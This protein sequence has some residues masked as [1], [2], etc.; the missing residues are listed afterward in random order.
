MNLA[1]QGMNPKIL[2]L[3]ETLRG[4]PQLD[5]PVKHYQIEGV[6]VR[7]LFLPKGT[8]LTGKIHNTEHISILS[9][10]ELMV[11]SEQGTFSLKAPYTVIDK[12]GTKRA[13]YAV[14]DCTFINVMRSDKLTIEDLEEELVS[15]TFEEFE[16]KR[17]SL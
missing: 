6:Y 14:T 4:M 8:V 9:Q 15:D 5:L 13:G 11:V 1:L 10:G 16:Q 2:E 12:P 17:L 7:E 3:E